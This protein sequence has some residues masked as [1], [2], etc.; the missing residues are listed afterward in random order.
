MTTRQRAVVLFAH[1]SRDPLWDMPLRAVAARLREECPSLPVVCA[2]LEMMAPDLE[3]AAAALIA[4]G[5]QQ[6]TVLPMFLGVGR[7][8]RHDLPAIV[9]RLRVL[10]PDVQFDL[11]PSVGEDQRVISLLATIAVE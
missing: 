8:A 6:L 5:T 11:R 1:G 2:F 9:E 7:H 10:H 4:S 3:Q